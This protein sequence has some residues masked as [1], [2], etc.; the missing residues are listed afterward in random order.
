MEKLI[1][2]LNN[3]YIMSTDV[4]D[5]PQAL[6][7]YGF[8]YTCERIADILKNCVYSD[9]QRMEKKHQIFI[10]STYEDLKEERK[11]QQKLYLP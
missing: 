5:K 7:R 10:S 2:A 4:I 8:G 3:N 9:Q 11:K 6:S 1:T